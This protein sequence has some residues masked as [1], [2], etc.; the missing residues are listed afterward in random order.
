[1]DRTVLAHDDAAVDTDAFAVGESACDG[2]AG[3]QVFGGLMVGGVD[4]CPIDDQEVSVSGGKPFS[5]VPYGVGQWQRNEPIRFARGCSE[6]LQLAFHRV[7]IGKMFICLIFALGI[8]QRIVWSQAHR[9]VYV[10]VGIVARQR[11]VVYPHDTLRMQPLLQFGSELCLRQRLYPCRR[12]LWSRPQAPSRHGL[13][14]VL[15][16]DF[17][18]RAGA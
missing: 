12:S 9:G 17:A 1:M 14:A 15:A 3:Q 16:T 6:G 4:D 8:E 10:P 5:V 11:A 2:I 18:R 13:C 7:E